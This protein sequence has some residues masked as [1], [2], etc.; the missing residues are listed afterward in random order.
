MTFTDTINY[1]Y[2]NGDSPRQTRL[3]IVN[4]LNISLNSLYR[5]KDTIPRLRQYQLESLTKG[6]LKVFD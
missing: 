5:W 1:F 4:L 6:E 2:K 3:R